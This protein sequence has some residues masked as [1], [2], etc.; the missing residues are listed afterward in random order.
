MWNQRLRVASTVES[1]RFQ[2]P[3]N[4]RFGPFGRH[5]ISPTSSVRDLD[6][7][8]V[9]EAH[10]ELVDVRLAHRARLVG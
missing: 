7:V 4:I 2:Y 9:D 3:A 5:T 8:V 6:V 10:V 1:G